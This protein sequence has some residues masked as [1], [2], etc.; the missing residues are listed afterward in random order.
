MYNITSFVVDWDQCGVFL[1]HNDGTYSSKKCDFAIQLVSL[2]E[3]C[4]N[5]GYLADVKRSIDGKRK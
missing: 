1:R 3:A 5:T 4:E 2:V